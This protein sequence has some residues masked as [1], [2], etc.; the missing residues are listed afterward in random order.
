MED[1][2]DEDLHEAI[3]DGDADEVEV[4]LERGANAESL[5]LDESALWLAVRR[6][7]RDIISML[8]R[9]GADPWR[10]IIGTRS[11]GSVALTGPLA[12]LFA[13]LPGAPSVD[14]AW[15]GRQRRADAVVAHY[16]TWSE[17]LEEGE[18][19][20]LVAGVDEDT[21]I[22]RLGLDPADCPTVGSRDYE[23]ALPG[24]GFEAYWLGTPPGGS[25]VA[26]LNLVGT[27][28]G[29]GHV[30]GPLSSPGPVVAV[31]TNVIA[32]TCIEIWRDGGNTRIF[33]SLHDPGQ[34]T[35]TEEWLCRFYDRSD[36]ST[37]GGMK[38]LALGTLLTG[39]Q[40]DEDWLFEAPKRLVVVPAA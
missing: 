23:E 33:Q 11:A 40:V 28:P 27:W 6:G 22:R 29:R 2:R 3:F 13:D 15:M 18:S 32:D 17:Y 36:D 35:T 14:P 8:L 20:A 24:V 1:A 34:E 30:W 26:L 31:S 10:L 21:A 39:V 7:N 5:Y 9:A 16:A 38:G 4:L 25:G 37:T 19:Y 12:D